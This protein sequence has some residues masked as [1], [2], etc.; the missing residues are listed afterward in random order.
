MDNYDFNI[1]GMIMNWYRPILVDLNLISTVIFI[2]IP[3]LS[4][5]LFFF[6]NRKFLWAA[7]ILSTILAVIISLIAAGPALLTVREYRRLF[8]G[9]TVPLQLIAAAVFTVIAYAAA[10]RFKSKKK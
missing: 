6:R 2:L 10:Y 3:V 5:V 8:L 9:I 4:V 1:R 7:S